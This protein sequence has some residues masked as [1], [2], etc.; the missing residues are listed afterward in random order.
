MVAPRL[1]FRL[2]LSCEL[3]RLPW[4]E[5]T[6]ARVEQHLPIPRGRGAAFLGG[7]RWWGVG[8]APH[9]D[10]AAVD[11]GGQVGLDAGD[12][13]G[14]AKTGGDTERGRGGERPGVGQGAAEGVD[15]VFAPPVQTV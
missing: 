12:A 1:A 6:V 15:P 8:V 7:V 5:G 4:G 3:G 9:H 2:L 10:R 13:A 11:V 14:A